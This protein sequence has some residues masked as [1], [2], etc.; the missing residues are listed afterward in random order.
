MMRKLAIQVSSL[1][2][3]GLDYLENT[4]SFLELIEIANDVKEVQESNG[5]QS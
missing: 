1:T 2:Y 5:K 4:I 3:T